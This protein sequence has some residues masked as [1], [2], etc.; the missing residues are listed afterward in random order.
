MRVNITALQSNHFDWECLD[1]F[2][3][4]DQTYIFFFPF[5]SAPLNEIFGFREGMAPC[6]YPCL[7]TA[8]NVGWIAESQTLNLTLLPVGPLLPSLLNPIN[9][10][11][12]QEVLGG[13]PVTQPE[14]LMTVSSPPQG[15][16]RAGEA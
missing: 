8:S 15:E 2:L 13:P 16:R 4:L 6:C 3:V 14:I 12:L 5:S 11:A 1:S 9:S 10:S 7:L